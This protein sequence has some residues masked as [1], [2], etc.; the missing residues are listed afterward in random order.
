MKNRA[1]K[2]LNRFAY[3]LFGTAFTK[4]IIAAWYIDPNCLQA[5]IFIG[6]PALWLARFT[7]VPGD[8]IFGLARSGDDDG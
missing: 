4:S 6:I 3:I 8:T 7:E 1:I 2:I 5:F